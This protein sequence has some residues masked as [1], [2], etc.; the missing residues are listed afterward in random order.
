MFAAKGLPRRNAARRSATAPV[1]WKSEGVPCEQTIPSRRFF[2]NFMNTQTTN[3]RAHRVP[4]DTRR[5]SPLRDRVLAQVPAPLSRFDEAFAAVEADDL[6]KWDTRSLRRDLVMRDGALVSSSPSSPGDGDGERLHPTRWAKGQMC[7]R[8]GIPAAYFA[9]CPA[10]LQDVQA[11]YW[12]KNGPLG[13]AR[14]ASEQEEDAELQSSLETPQPPTSRSIKEKNQI[15]NERWL[16][17]ASGDTLR[18]VL[19][20]TYK[21]ATVR[22]ARAAHPS[23]FAGGLVRAKR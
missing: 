12:L 5:F 19:S 20:S 15:E 18:A 13:T 14:R 11:N 8:L 6:P 23:A 9:A 1:A 2:D 21:Q 16:L 3:G 22:D 10:I 17:R 4:G 7:A